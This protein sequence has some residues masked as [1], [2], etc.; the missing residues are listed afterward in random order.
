LKPTAPT[1]VFTWGNP[2]RGDDALG[3]LF[4][5]ELLHGDFEDVDV[6]TDFQ[7]QIEHCIDLENRKRVIFVDADININSEY[8]LEKILPDNDSTFTTHAMS[9]QALMHVCSQVN[10]SELPECW[11]LKIR[12]FT[13]E[14]GQPLSQAAQ[15][16][17]DSALTATKTFLRNEI[18]S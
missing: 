6:L 9:P 8:S 1:L 18:P 3:C 17:L 5:D 15:H 7:L 11:L 4:H 14:L 2:S 10:Q 16:N 13:F 12:G